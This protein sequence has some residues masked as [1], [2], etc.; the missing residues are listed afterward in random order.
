MKGVIFF[1]FLSL[2][3]ACSYFK[4]GNKKED[5]IARANDKYLYLSDLEGV[6]KGAARPEDSMQAVRNYIDSWIRHN[7]LLRY[8]E[9]NLPETNEALDK[10]LRDYRESLLIYTYEK[11]LLNDKL[12][13]VVNEQEIQEYYSEN[14][15]NFELKQ[16]ITR[17]KYIMLPMN[18][19]VQLDSIR[20]WMRRTTE[21]NY[22]KLKGF[23]SENATRFAIS[24]S[25]WY[26][27]DEVVALLPVD[28]FNFENAQYNKSY[29]EVE[30][31]GYAYLIKFEEYR[32]KGSDAPMDFVRDEIRN[33]I[34][35][36]RKLAFIG[37]IHK[38]IYEEASGK[39]EFDIY[40]DSI[41]LKK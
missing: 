21:D 29:L 11:E 35:N 22:P 26:N 31:S 33:I 28:K 39:N 8:A 14:K 37:S 4:S 1:L 12:D 6:G 17:I 40:L 20:K 30:D 27:K 24:D 7:L 5:P 25:T 9:D 18:T 3:A 23:C 34:I 13:T 32:I 10:Q 19:R 41:P 16:C 36:K 38:N 15:D 2:L